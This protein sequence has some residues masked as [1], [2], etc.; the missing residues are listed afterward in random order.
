MGIN[1]ENDKCR[2]CKLARTPE[3]H[4]P[5]LGELPGVLFACCGH[6]NGAGYIY[7]QNGVQVRFGFCSIEQVSPDELARG[8]ALKQ[9]ELFEAYK[10]R[11][12]NSNG[13]SRARTRSDRWANKSSEG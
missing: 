1:W 3:G 5:C 4:D 9:S 6:G 11:R 7:F 12:L 13:L 10:L 2:K 8:R